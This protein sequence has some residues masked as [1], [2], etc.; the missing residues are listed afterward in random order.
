M[1][2]NCEHGVETELYWAAISYIADTDPSEVIDISVRVA[3]RC[4]ED[5]GHTIGV[6]PSPHSD[7]HWLCKFDA[8]NEREEIEHIN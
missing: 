5:H 6:W 7:A 4:D 3:I 1:S 8:A 2:D